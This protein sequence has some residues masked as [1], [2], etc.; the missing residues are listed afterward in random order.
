MSGYPHAIHEVDPSSKHKKWAHNGS[1]AKMSE[2]L[3][4]KL[5]EENI[6]VNLHDLRLGKDFLTWY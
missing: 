6:G 1:K 2:C 4:T 5:L 3:I